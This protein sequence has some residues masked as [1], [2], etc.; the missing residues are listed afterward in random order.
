MHSVRP[1]SVFFLDKKLR[2]NNE[3]NNCGKHVVMCDDG[4]GSK[5][6]ENS[7]K[8]LPSSAAAH[9]VTNVAGPSPASRRNLSFSEDAING[10]FHHGGV[11]TDVSYFCQLNECLNECFGSQS[12]EMLTGERTVHV[13]FNAIA[14]E[15]T[16]QKVGGRGTEILQKNCDDGKHP[17]LQ[18]VVDQVVSASKSS[19][20]HNLLHGEF[21]VE[22]EGGSTCGSDGALMV[23]QNHARIEA[24]HTHRDDDVAVRIFEH[25]DASYVIINDC[26]VLRYKKENKICYK[27]EAILQ[28]SL[29]EGTMRASLF[30]LGCLKRGFELLMYQ[31]GRAEQCLKEILNCDESMVDDETK[32]Q[33]LSISS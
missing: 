3:T 25:D 30:G 12:S 9:C 18:M 21:V 33:L 6:L 7:E 17:F 28:F 32:K 10:F 16:E 26:T 29:F 11:D 1:L 5:N 15:K 4:R 8:F 24:R 23:F 14:P 27:S 31:C 19:K 22:R 13:Y 20:L 2:N